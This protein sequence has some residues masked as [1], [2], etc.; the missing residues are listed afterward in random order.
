MNPS[1]LIGIVVYNRWE[2]T[3]KLITSILNTNYSNFQIS[4]IDNASYDQTV[5]NLDQFSN[6]IKIICNKSR[7]SFAHC[8]NQVLNADADLYCLMTNEIEIDTEDWLQNLVEKIQSDPMNGICV[9][10]KRAYGKYLI[11]GKLTTNATCLNIFKEK[12][13]EIEWVHSCCF[14]LKKFLLHKIGK[15]DE[16][17]KVRY[18]E[19]VDFC[20]RATDYNYKIVYDDRVEI[21]FFENEPIELKMCQDINR[22]L[23]VEKNENW[24]IEHKGK[25]EKL[26]RRRKRI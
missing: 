18:Y 14:L 15:F 20:V 6:K 2:S 3:K 10:V 17:F 26:T 24:L 7:Q 16:Q 19:D 9:P 13:E 8:F 11:G 22:Q 1:V 4:I 21:S 12:F 5:N 23:F 25:A